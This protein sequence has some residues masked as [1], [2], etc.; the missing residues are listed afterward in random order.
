[1][2]NVIY[3]IIMSFQENTYNCSKSSSTT[4]TK[5]K[6]NY[7]TSATPTNPR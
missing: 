3:K 4:R 5:G 1:M 2:A 7:R 6:V